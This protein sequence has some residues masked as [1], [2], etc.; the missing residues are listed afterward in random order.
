MRMNR[1]SRRFEGPIR[2]RADESREIVRA[3][4]EMIKN[5]GKQAAG[6][7]ERRAKMLLASDQSGPAAT[8]QVI[9][10]AVRRIEAGPGSALR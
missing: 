5:H 9:A 3:A 2:D 4:R 8:W 1:G 10:D 6:E 7:A